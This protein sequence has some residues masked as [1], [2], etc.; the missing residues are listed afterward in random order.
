[1]KVWQTFII[2]ASAA[3][4]LA[5]GLGAQAGAAPQGGEA[6]ALIQLPG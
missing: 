6:Q 4:A 1:M 3:A 2:A 5:I